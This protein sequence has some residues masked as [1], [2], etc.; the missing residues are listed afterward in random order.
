MKSG[1][2]GKP[3]RYPPFD[4]RLLLGDVT[5]TRVV[6]RMPEGTNPLVAQDQV[7]SCP[8][9]ERKHNWRL[10]ERRLSAGLF[11]SQIQTAVWV[12]GL[13]RQQQLRLIKEARD[14]LHEANQGEFM[15]AFMVISIKVVSYSDIIRDCII[16]LRRKE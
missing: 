10:Q 2:R 1:P 9:F 11:T 3:L 6:R 12:A 5:Q 7:N 15:W 14:M 16:H 4:L 8:S 13:H